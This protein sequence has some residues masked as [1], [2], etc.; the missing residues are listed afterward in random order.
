MSVAFPLLFLMNFV[1]ECLIFW[2]WL[3]QLP[4]K[5]VCPYCSTKLFNCSSLLKEFHIV[6]SVLQKDWNS[7]STQLF[8]CFQESGVNQYLSFL[9]QNFCLCF[10]PKNQFSK[11]INFISHIFKYRVSKIK[12]NQMNDFQII[13]YSK[14]IPKIFASGIVKFKKRQY[15]IQW[16]RI[17]LGKISN[18]LIQQIIQFS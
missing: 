10:L 12:F 15:L 2:K 9:N 16:V 8:I 11:L 6:F 17:H 7:L 13:K 1:W 4:S 5:P 3:F 14:I 18:H